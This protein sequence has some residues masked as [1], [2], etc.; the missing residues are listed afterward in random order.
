MTTVL[1]AALGYAVFCGV[2][3]CTAKKTPIKIEGLFEHGFAS[4]TRD[5]AVIKEAWTKYRAADIGLALPPGVLVV[6]VDVVR[7]KKGRGDF[8]RLFGCQP[9]EMATAVSTTA[10]GGWHVYFRFAPSLQL[11][12]TTITSSLDVRIGGLGYVIAPSPGNGRRWIQPLVSTPLLE[13][14]Q[15]LLE[16]LTRVP[17][18]E[19]GEAKPFLGETSERARQTL[20]RA[21]ATLAA[22]PPGTRDATIGQVVYRVGRL[23]AAGELDAESALAVLLKAM[24]SNPG[25]DKSHR[26]KVERCFR[27]GLNNPAEPGP[28]G[29]VHSIDDDFGDADDDGERASSASIPQQQQA[30]SAGEAQSTSSGWEPIDLDLFLAGSDLPPPE[31]S[32][33]ALPQGWAEVI[34]TYAAVAEAPPDY[35]AIASIAGAAGAIGNAYVVEGKRGWR[36]PAVLWGMAIGPP[37]AHKT[38]ALKAAHSALA[39]IDHELYVEWKKECEQVEIQHQMALDAQEAANKPKKAV[40][41]PE[42]RSLK[43]LLHDDTSLEK[44]TINMA[45]SPHGAVAFYSELAAWF[46]SFSRYSSSGDDSSGRAL[47]NRA[48]DAERFKRDRVKNEGP[49]IVVPAAA[50]SVV[51]AIQPDKL[52]QIWPKS[53]DGLLARPIYVWPRLAPLPSEESE[54][55]GDD[56]SGGETYAFRK[57]FKALYGLPLVVVDDGVAQSA[58]LRLASEARLPFNAAKRDCERRARREHGLI[59]EWLGKGPGR[60]LRLALTFELMT[61]SLSSGARPTSIDLDALERA[62]RYFQYAEGMLRR[63]L[64]GLEPTRSAE[65][66]L[67]V[68]KRIVQQSWLHFTNN[69]VG[70]EQGFRRFRGEDAENKRRRDNALKVLIDANA[71]RQHLV[72]TGRGAIQKWAVNPDLG[73]KI[74]D[75]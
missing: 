42:K 27:D 1:E 52:R 9:E 11:V 45:A 33:D 23:A 55:N 67:A 6:D 35:V 14:P 18:L 56:I 28:I 3:P 22:A 60:I 13:A 29:D 16:R 24:A 49:P 47:W 37:S 73:E 57:A 15:W 4:A 74:R 61:W 25:T 54:K 7:G 38:P 5:P 69:D 75:L 19:P 40:K 2:F 72:P 31:L 34:R 46:A 26:D 10:R 32:D 63:T 39:A 70:R 30:S 8:V 66:A 12:Q 43:H 71:I 48:Y 17:E 50:C 68:A 41:K 36:E 53:H 59:G 62:I 58:V 64:A 51:G 20:V 44:L 65:D 21:C